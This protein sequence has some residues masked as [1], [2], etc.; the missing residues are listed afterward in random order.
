MNSVHGLIGAKSRLSF[1]NAERLMNISASCR[2]SV[3]GLCS[4][5]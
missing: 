3:H 5:Q 2:G 1:A 4:G